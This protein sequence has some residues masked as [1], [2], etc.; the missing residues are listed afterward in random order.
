MSNK[1]SEAI[2]DADKLKLSQ[3][4]F[5]GFQHTLAMFGATILVPILTGLHVSVAL[6]T[7]GLGTLV[8]HYLTGKKVPAYLG[9]SFAFIAPISV[10]ISNA[11]GIPAA[12]GGIIVTGIVYAIVSWLIYKLG[13]EN[14][15]RVFPPIVTGPIIMVIG[16]YLAD[17]AID[18]ASGNVWVAAAALIG[19]TISA[20]YGR[21]F[22]KIIPV[23]T[24]LVVG[25]LAALAAGIVDFTPVMEAGWVGLP[26]FTVP[27]FEINAIS[28][29]APVAVVSIIEHVGDIL[30]ISETIGKGRE[31]VVDPG[32]NKTMIGDGVATI[33]AGIFGGPPNTT[34][35]ENT[36]VL[37]L[38]KVF[39]S[40]VMRI[41]AVFA[42]MLSLVPKFGELIQTIPEPV[43]GGISILLFGMIASVGI[44]TLI[45]SGSD[46]KRSRNLIIVSVI[47]VLGLGGA[48]IELGEMEFSGMALAAVVG[49]VLNLVL[50]RETDKLLNDKREQN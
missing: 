48:V 8:F 29:I 32:L 24:G 19:A 23:I 22:F 43:I 11:G 10:V 20:V 38:T 44:R 42:V 31:L 36:G 1:E 15:R 16:L 30:A 49:I 40:K 47:L 41:G 27:A 17:V 5:V 39:D 26:Q 21:G 12:Q 14:I 9:S 4:I 6:F 3:E 37:A 45:E 7:S 2:R 25:Y 50:P 28:I 34:Y 18:Q 33:L 35:G 46:L 13:P